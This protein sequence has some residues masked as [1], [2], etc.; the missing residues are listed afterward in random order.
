M[1]LTQLVQISGIVAA[2]FTVGTVIVTRTIPWLKT[3]WDSR[4][5][6]KRLGTIFIKSQLER[7]LRYYVPPMCQD[8]DPAGAEEP[9]L[10]FTVRQKLFEVL[11]AAS[12]N[13]SQYKYIFLLADS[14]MGKT[15]ALIGYFARH[16]RMWRKPFKLSLIPLG[17]PDADRRIG[18]IP[19]KEETF[20]LLDA[21]DED[22]LA[23]VDHVERLRDLMRITSSFQRVLISCRTQ[24][25]AKDEEIPL[26]S[27]IIK[28]ASRAAGEPAEYLFHKIYL[29][30]FSN[31]E[32]EEYIQRRY[33]LWQMRARQTTR[34]FISKIPHLSVRPMLL[35]HLD[36]LVDAHRE[37]RWSFE[38]YG[39]MINAWLI[40]EQGF[41]PNTEVLLEFS[42]LLAV[43][44]LVNRAKRGSEMVPKEELSALAEQWGI[45]I[46][47]WVLTGRS[48]LNRDADGNWKFAH[49]SIMEYLVL[50]RIVKTG[51]IYFD[52]PWTDQ[53]DS[54]LREMNESYLSTRNLLATV[55]ICGKESKYIKKVIK[56]LALQT[57]PVVITEI[58]EV[59]RL[60]LESNH[61]DSGLLIIIGEGDTGVPDVIA[62]RLYNILS[63]EPL[64]RRIPRSY[65]ALEFLD[66]P[67]SSEL[68]L[69]Q[70]YRVITDSDLIPDWCKE[71]FSK[72][73]LLLKIGNER[74]VHYYLACA[75]SRAGKGL[76]KFIQVLNSALFYINFE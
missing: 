69:T 55:G 46:D 15:S 52:V 54:F 50:I 8:I 21:F 19:D 4:S 64:L 60:I 14:G 5:L 9:R 3:K 34:A 17:I 7:T 16:L 44:L 43:N 38:L 23:I 66:K 71:S 48:L 29:S 18:E 36:D 58:L 33:P 62:A 72:K 31:D 57:K 73:Y 39:E 2:V 65:G 24:F 37:L 63:P 41:I 26:R 25:F 75:A 70:A 32:I 49:R 22:T 51:N 76:I 61:K 30:P 35:A 20:L 68:D 11:D 6:Y 13:P 40:R 45:L 27:G 74:Q 53:I 59:C 12:G 10:V 42:E 67:L 1:T 28:V 47:N 56:D